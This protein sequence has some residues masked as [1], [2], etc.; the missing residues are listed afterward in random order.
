MLKKIYMVD[1]IVRLK[2]DGIKR[3]GRTEREKIGR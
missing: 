3:K 1:K 2:E